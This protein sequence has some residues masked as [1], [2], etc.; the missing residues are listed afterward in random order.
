MPGGRPSA[1]NRVVRFRERDGVR[2]PV[3]VFDAI[4]GSLRIG[5]YLET[6]AAQCDV[7]A[8]TIRGWL[9]IGAKVSTR[10]AL[11][12]TPVDQLDLT[13]HERRCHEFSASVAQAE[14]DYELAEQSTLHR[15]GRGG[16][17]RST[18]RV[19]T[20]RRENADGAVEYIETER[21]VTTETLAPDPRVI[22]WRLTRRFPERYQHTHDG[23]GTDPF[24]DDGEVTGD[25][26]DELRSYLQGVEDTEA[27]KRKPRARKA[28]A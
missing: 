25:L 4:V 22:M 19:K 23:A 16:M 9:R 6:A 10:S 15:L 5:S 2:E 8:Q 7:D 11:E 28:K 18:S 24:A 13:D 26:V 14:A 21:V 20:E 1:I 3:T 17:T 27:A 12:S